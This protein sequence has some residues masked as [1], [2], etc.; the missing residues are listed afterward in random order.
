MNPGWAGPV[1][2]EPSPATDAPVPV[3]ARAGASAANYRADGGESADF[4]VLAA[5]VAGP[6]HRLGGGRCEDSYAWVKPRP[7]RLGLLIADGVSTAGRGGEG[8]DLAVEAAARYLSSCEGWGETECRGAA[9]RAS[10]EL[11]SAGHVLARGKAAELSTTFVVALVAARVAG[12]DVVLGRVG[13]STAFTLTAGLWQELFIPPD[14]DDLQRVA[15]DVLPFSGDAGNDP[16]ETASAYL[17]VG[18]AIVL[19]TDGLANPLRDG[20]TTV[21]PGLAE[22]LGEG[23]GR[24][25]SPLALAAAADFSRRGCQD[26][27]TIVVAWPRPSG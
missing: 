13:D 17:D 11:M 12:A 3:R 23:S 9:A 19:V 7:G 25:P 18:T 26:D 4:I 24:A 27:R 6:V 8:A 2:G 21:A 22:V 1:W 5:S 16:I 10:A 20:P 15:T 14:D